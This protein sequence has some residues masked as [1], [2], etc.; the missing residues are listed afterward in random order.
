MGR[1]ELKNIPYGYC[2]C[3][4]GQKTTIAKKTNTKAGWVA[5][6]PRFYIHGHHVGIGP[7]NRNW[8]GGKFI[9][10]SRN[11]SYVSAYA[12]GHPRGRYVFEHILVAERVL[13]KV[14]P[15]GTVVHHIDGNG[16]NNANNNLVICQDEV[17]HKLLHK[18]DAAY[19]ASGHPDWPKCQFCKRHD[20]P[21]NLRFY[22]TNICHQQCNKEYQRKRRERICRQNQV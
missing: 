20:H 22:G 4:C 5:G 3:G 17:Y 11:K 7:D 15:I 14:L 19:K 8:S 1:P 13:G 6:K 2:H 10:K 16:L 18:R 12:P 21:D 9:R